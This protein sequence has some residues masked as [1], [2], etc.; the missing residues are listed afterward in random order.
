MPIVKGQ[1]R[2]AGY[3][4]AVLRREYKRWQSYFDV[5]LGNPEQVRHLVP[6]DGGNV[7]KRG[8][9]YGCVYVNSTN[10]RTLTVTLGSKMRRLD[11]SLTGQVVLPPHSG[12]VLLYQDVN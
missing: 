9:T 1:R 10:H 4:L 2:D 8:F 3:S 7:W 6:T 11:G 5:G 12:V